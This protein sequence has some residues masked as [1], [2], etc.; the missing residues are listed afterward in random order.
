MISSAMAPVQAFHQWH[1][2]AIESGTKQA[3]LFAVAIPFI[4]VT[5]IVLALRVYVRLRLL[6]VK[7]MMDDCE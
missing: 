3:S 4:L 5:L 2:R 6:S 7:L 1:A